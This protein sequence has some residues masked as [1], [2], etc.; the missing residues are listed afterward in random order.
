MLAQS[1]IFLKMLGDDLRWNL[2]KALVESDR[3]VQELVQ[4]LQKPQNL[5]SYH[6]K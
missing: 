5:V 6:L 3:K 4:I 1:P 2:I